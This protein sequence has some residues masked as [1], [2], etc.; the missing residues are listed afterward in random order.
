MSHTL[1]AAFDNLNE[2]NAARDALLRKKVMDSNINISSSSDE[3]VAIGNSPLGTGAVHDHDESFGDKVSHFFS[4]LF[5]SDNDDRVN[6][7]VSAYSDAYRNG[8]TVLTVTVDD[9]DDVLLAQEILEQNGAFDIDERAAT[10]G[11][12]GA[13]HLAGNHLA[14]NHLGAASASVGHTAAG[15]D[16]R[17]AIPVIQEDLRVGKRQVDTG[18]VRVI[19]RLTER[20]VEETVNL[21]EE[22]AEI[23]RRPVDRAA[24]AGEL[25]TFREGSIEIQ[26]TAEQ[27]VVQKTARVVEEVVVRKEASEHQE[28][29]RDTVRN[30]EVDIQKDGVLKDGVLKDN[31][32]TDR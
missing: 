25:D 21:R 31:V 1:I 11:S 12:Q 27:A 24:T 30:T 6:Q 23:E 3:T 2:A 28:T 13:T 8:A 15:L 14:G 20:P 9:D 18:R 16:G 22:H 26:E 10:W 4:S 32:R 7:H 29:I 5:G 19:S 17:A